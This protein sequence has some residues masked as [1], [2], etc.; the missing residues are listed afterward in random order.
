MQPIRQ[1][2]EGSLLSLPQV[3]RLCMKADIGFT[4]CLFFRTTTQRPGICTI[5]LVSKN[6]SGISPTIS[7][8]FQFDVGRSSAIFAD[9]LGWSQRDDGR[10]GGRRVLSR[11]FGRSSRRLRRSSSVRALR[12]LLRLLF[13]L[14][15]NRR[16]IDRTRQLVD[17]KLTALVGESYNR[18]VSRVRCV[19]WKRC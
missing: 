4:N 8:C 16:Y 9:A 5:G 17:T 15:C 2:D 10:L 7:R 19:C 3:K 12:F 1:R 6:T 14:P 13:T 18:L 11:H